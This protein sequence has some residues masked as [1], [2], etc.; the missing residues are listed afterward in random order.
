MRI[1]KGTYAGDG[2]DNRGL[3]AGMTWTPAMGWIISQSHG[4]LTIRLA[5]M[6]SGKSIRWSD[7]TSEIDTGIKALI[8]GGATLGT[9]GY[10][11]SSGATYHYVFFEAD[12]AV[13][14]QGSYTGNASDD[15]AITA[16][17]EPCFAAVRCSDQ[18]YHTG[19]KWATIP[20]QTTYRV[21]VSGTIATNA[22]QSLGS[23]GFTVGTDDSV[24]H[25]GK[26]YYWFAFAAQPFL[27]QSSFAGDGSD[28]RDISEDFEPEV[29]WL[30]NENGVAYTV[31]RLATMEGDQS[32]RLGAY[33]DPTGKPD[34]IQ[35]IQSGGF[36]VGT[37]TD[38]NQASVAIHYL[39]FKT[40]IPVVVAEDLPI[41]H[42]TSVRLG[43]SLPVEHLIRLRR[44]EDL[45]VEW[46]GLWLA[47][48]DSFIILAPFSDVF[49]DS[50][51]IAAQHLEPFVDSFTIKENLAGAEFIDS[52]VILPGKLVPLFDEDVQLPFAEVTLED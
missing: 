2:N 29:V 20:G 22:I 11:N 27:V 43:A 6:P 41:E 23:N 48:A 47:I 34:R 16:D 38:V 35:A 18:G 30:T 40:A 14:A 52:F 24:N 8:A 39:A 3:D 25:S 1:V 10:V 12:P 31:L 7:T 51:R 49:L 36:Q 45:A 44:A 21:S 46:A 37:S 42:L 50:F 13:L 4:E 33:E 9:S 32:I 17:L 5:A 26:T 28:N 15:R 19:V